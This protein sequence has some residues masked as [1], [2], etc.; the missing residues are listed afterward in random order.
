MGPRKDAAQ[1][2]RNYNNIPCL[3]SYMCLSILPNTIKLQLRVNWMQFQANKALNMKRFKLL[4]TRC[5]MYDASGL[6]QYN[7]TRGQPRTFIPPPLNLTKWNF[8]ALCSYLLH[9]IKMITFNVWKLK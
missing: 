7:L 3:L 9:G 6:S 4:A 8:P 5:R 1:C 2:I